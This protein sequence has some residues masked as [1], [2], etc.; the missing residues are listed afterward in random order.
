[1]R[2]ARGTHHEHG[3]ASDGRAAVVVERA[4]AV[5]GGPGDQQ[6]TA[7]HLDVAVAVDGIADGIH[8]QV[9]AVDLDEAVVIGLAHAAACRGA[10]A[11]LAGIGGTARII[12]GRQLGRAS[13]LLSTGSIGG[14]TTLLR[15]RSFRGLPTLRGACGCL[16]AGV[17][18]RR[19]AALAGHTGRAT[20]GQRGAHRIGVGIVGQVGSAGVHAVIACHD[21][22]VAAVD[23]DLLRFVA[24]ITAG[25]VHGSVV[26]GQLR[27]R[28]E[29]VVAGAHLYRGAQQMH[30]QIGMER[31]IVGR[32]RHR[33]ARKTDERLA[34]H[35]IVTG[36]DVERAAVDAHETLRR[37]VVLVRLDAV[38]ARFDGEDAVADLH[39]IATAQAVFHGAD[40]VRS[41]YHH[42]IVLRA[43]RVA[44]RARHV[45][46][47]GPVQRQ[48]AAAE[49]RGIGLIGIIF[50]RT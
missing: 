23:V 50:Q 41:R 32:H 13:A 45:Q 46:R 47:P 3:A 22:R 27:L 48:V 38:A 40:V 16:A 5:A 28:M 12:A 43:H 33:A 25:H 26:H 29:R 49:Q 18:S 20:V 1:M 4:V 42:Q 15:A 24:L 11:L 30:L 7:R 39:A 8:H 21:V 44:I 37:L 6:H 9:A 19:A 10:S 36:L 14:L 17:L 31:V 2:H 34:L 35:R